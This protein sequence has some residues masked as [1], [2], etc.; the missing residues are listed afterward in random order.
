MGDIFRPPHPSRGGY[1]PGKA[2]DFACK[3][4]GLVCCGYN[5]AAPIPYVQAAI[6]N[7]T[8]PYL[9]SNTV[10]SDEFINGSKC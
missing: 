3:S 6:L 1:S 9:K 4:F 5:R 2:K 7:P 8:H 10:L